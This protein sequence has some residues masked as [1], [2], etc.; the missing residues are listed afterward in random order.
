LIN[1]IRR[2]KPFEPFWAPVGVN[3][4]TN[5]P[6]CYPFPT[7]RRI[8]LWDLPGAGTSS[9]PLETY[10]ARMGL[11]YFDAVL[12][13]SSSRFTRA[14]IE[15]SKELDDFEVPYYMVRTKVDLDVDNNIK[16]NGLEASATLQQIIEDFRH[17]GISSPYLVSSRDPDKYDL[18]RLVCE[19]FPTLRQIFDP[20]SDE[21]SWMDDLWA[22]PEAYSELV[23]GIQ[24]LWQNDGISY[25]VQGKEVHVTR[26]DGSCAE[27]S[28]LETDDRLWWGKHWYIELAA[29]TK[30][31]GTGEL[32]FQVSQKGVRTFSWSRSLCT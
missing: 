32:H 31:L 25:L 12:L 21:H 7:E 10:V 8:R 30:A 19:I 27:V 9:F 15:V 11:R 22:I 2:V 6:T 17:R 14:E 1:S 13:V 24:G 28:L 3:E 23:S 20:E 26:L 16:D 18:R 5:E 4:T 29:V